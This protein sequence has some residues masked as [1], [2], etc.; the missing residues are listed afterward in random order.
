MQVFLSYAHPDGA[1][2]E[3]LQSYLEKK[4]FSVWNPQAD[5]LP[6]DNI[7]L[8]NGEAL[9]NSKAMVVL[10]SPESMRS[11]WVR[12]EI[13]YALGD[14][15]YEGRLFPVQ[16]RPT[17]SM[18]WILPEFKILDAKRGVNKIGETIADALKQVA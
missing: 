16:V 15:K 14:Q 11:E 12:G 13:Q 6:G 8:R 2:A 3:A 4:G 9:K 5:L 10:I 17:S 7:F 1:L 18:P